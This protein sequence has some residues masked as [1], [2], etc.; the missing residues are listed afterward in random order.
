M[1]WSTNGIRWQGVD[2]PVHKIFYTCKTIYGSGDR[3]HCGAQLVSRNENG[4]RTELQYKKT[5]DSILLSLFMKTNRICINSYA[6]S[7]V[8]SGSLLSDH[9]KS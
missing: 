1:E 3:R 4:G 7:T 5:T 8:L 9:V 2:R 6:P